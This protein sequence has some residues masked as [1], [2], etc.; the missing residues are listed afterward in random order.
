MKPTLTIPVWVQDLVVTW[1]RPQVTLNK[2]VRWSKYRKRGTRRQD[3]LQHTL[4]LVFFAIW[5]LPQFRKH[6]KF[7]ELF[8]LRALIVHDFGEGETKSGD[9]LYIDKDHASDLAETRAFVSRYGVVIGEDLTRAFLL[10]FAKN[11]N[12]MEDFTGILRGLKKQYPVE[13][14][15]FDALERFDYFLYALEQYQKLGKAKILVQVLRNNAPHF[16]RLSRNLPGFKQVLWR[17]DLAGWCTLFLN[18]Y[19]DQWIEKKGEK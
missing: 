17:P 1:A 11:A 13:C 9:T 16:E 8:L 15:L 19:D 12:Q 10:Q 5:A 4:S 3:T 14:L 7:D 6:A 18:R 2:V